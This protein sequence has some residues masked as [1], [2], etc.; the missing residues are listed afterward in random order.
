MNTEPRQKSELE[1]YK[2]LDEALV[3]IKEKDR[4]IAY[5]ERQIEV[6]QTL[7]AKMGLVLNKT[8]I[9]DLFDKKMMECRARDLAEGTL[10]HYREAKHYFTTWCRTRGIEWADEVTRDHTYEFWEWLKVT[11][12]IQGRILGEFARTH[13][14]KSTKATFQYAEEIN[15]IVRN[16]FPNKVFP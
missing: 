15:A 14:Y 6:A 4:L 10:R 3:A 9:E 7:Q 8:T 1:R 11:P 16:P 13:R 12:G 5:L 2:T